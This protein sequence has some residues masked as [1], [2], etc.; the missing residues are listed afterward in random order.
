MGMQELY[1]YAGTVA[2]GGALGGGAAGAIPSR[3]ISAQYFDDRPAGVPG[4]LV[5]L[6]RGIRSGALIV[7]LMDAAGT[8]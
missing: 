8:S 2:A 4:R 5:G 3:A 7:D 1:G 6:V